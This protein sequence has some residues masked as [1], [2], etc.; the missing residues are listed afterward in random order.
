MSPSTFWSGLILATSSIAVLHLG[1]PIVS[2]FG[3][4]LGCHCGVNL[5]VNL[6]EPF[7]ET[8]TRPQN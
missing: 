2:S 8:S 6:D 5:N 3:V 7:L 4:R 1:Q